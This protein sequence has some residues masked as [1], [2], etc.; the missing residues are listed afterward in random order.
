MKKAK[1]STPAKPLP[2]CRECG[3]R[4]QMCDS[5]SRC[6]QCWSMAAHA[7]LAPM[8]GQW[9]TEGLTLQRIADRLNVEGHTT[10]RGKPW[11]PGRSVEYPSPL[12]VPAEPVL[13][14]GNRW[15]AAGSAAVPPSG[16]GLLTPNPGL[17]PGFLFA[18]ARHAVAPSGPGGRLS[19]AR[20]VRT[21]LAWI[22]MSALLLTFFALFCEELR[23]S[24]DAAATERY[25]SLN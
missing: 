17:P 3:E 7:D 11:N 5:G 25:K 1:K 22:P 13:R 19:V 15:P 14:T 10:R 16:A 6:E 23:N 12:A 18:H 8:M 2:P 24:L 21:R 4:P 9:R 20:P